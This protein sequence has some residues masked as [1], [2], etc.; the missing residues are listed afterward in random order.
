MSLLS[1]IRSFYLVLHGK[2]YKRYGKHSALEKTLWVFSDPIACWALQ[3]CVQRSARYTSDIT[4]GGLQ[5]ELVRET[6]DQKQ[7]GHKSS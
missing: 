4:G 2:G 6:Q 7:N 1:G 5:P 3:H